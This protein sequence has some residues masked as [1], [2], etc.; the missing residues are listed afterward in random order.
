MI[1]KWKDCSR[2]IRIFYQKI[3]AQVSYQKLGS[4]LEQVTK[5]HKLLPGLR[6]LGGVPF[7]LTCGLLLIPACQP[8]ISSP[9]LK[10]GTL[11]PITGDLSQYGTSMQNS[12]ELLVKTV[13][14]CGGVLGQPVVLITED[15]QTEPAA[16]AAAMTKLAEVDRG[17]GVIGAA[18]S[19]VSS[20]AVDV[21]VRN[22]VV[23]ISPSSTSPVFTER[24]R[25]GDFQGFWFR[26]APPD[27][28]QGKALA[29]LAQQQGF[30]TISLLA[31]NNDYG[32]G[33]LASF[34]P[35]FEGLGGTVVNKAKPVRYPPDASG[36]ASEVNAAFSGE[37]DA[38]LLIAYPET[39]SLILKTAYQQGLLGGKTRVM[40]TDGL[41]EAGFAELVGQSAKG[42]YVAAGLMGTAASAGGPAIADFQRLYTQT[43]SRSP[44]IYDP[45]TWDAA[46]VLV[47][48]AE[49]AK[50]TTGSVIKEHIRAI[51]NPPGTPV[52]DVCQALAQIRQGQK[53]NYQGASGT[54]DFNPF[55]DITGSYDVW[56]IQPDGALQVTGAIAVT[57]R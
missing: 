29:Q 41:K 48:A 9:Q 45:N 8:S 24:A 33:L 40:A 3:L 34:I 4:C 22:Q 25:K 36:F 26:T 19:A 28:F 1:L 39:G 44:K 11:L 23:M 30:K 47:L 20:A 56:V 27:T 49:A 52:T 17:A 35:A 18:S 50:S 54:L 46:A 37:P 57:D 16:G 10:L 51:A 5:L 21:A 38:V 43:Y 55:G 32:N 42:D 12:A 15:D 31:V 14:G 6:F 2:F 13:N 53:I 7:L